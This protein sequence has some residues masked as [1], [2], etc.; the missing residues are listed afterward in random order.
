M[1]S[2]DPVVNTTFWSQHGSFSQDQPILRQDTCFTQGR[3]QCLWVSSQ[4]DS[5]NPNSFKGWWGDLR[6]SL[7]VLSSCYKVFSWRHSRKWTTERCGGQDSWDCWWWEV[8]S[9]CFSDSFW[10]VLPLD[11]V[12]RRTL[13]TKSPQKSLIWL[14]HVLD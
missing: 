14:F 11:L 4:E 13:G 3:C 12:Q 10:P 7:G 8:H 2:F 9:D 5:R 1:L 6:Q